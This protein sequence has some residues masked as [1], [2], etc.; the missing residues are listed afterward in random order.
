MLISISRRF[1]F[2]AVS[3]TGSTAI[4]SALASAADVSASAGP[5]AKHA[6]IARILKEYDSLFS[7][8]RYCA[9]SFFKFAVLRDPVDRLNSW[10]RYR[11]GNNPR[12]RL[13]PETSFLE[14]LEMKDFAL[15]RPED[16]RPNAQIEYLRDETGRLLVDYLIPYEKLEQHFEILSR[17]I[18]GT[19]KLQRQNVSRITAKDSPVPD[20]LL[21]KLHD[22]FWEDYELIERLP[23]IN[24]RGLARLCETRAFA[25]NRYRS[26]D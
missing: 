7:Q 1:I 20:Q 6:G 2:V 25:E 18:G 17:G 11:I 4:E 26:F 14:F 21:P 9:E 22:F 12:S 23:E 15:V 24:E 5:A 19:G 10:Y 13:P 8:E 16:G 3:K